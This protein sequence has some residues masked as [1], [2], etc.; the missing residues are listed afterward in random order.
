MRTSLLWLA[1]L[2]VAATAL[3]QPVP[4]PDQPKRATPP[5]EK[6]LVIRG[7]LKASDPLDR[8]RKQSYCRVHEVDL[9]AGRTYLVELRSPDFDT[10]L[11]VEDTQGRVLAENDDIGKTD[12]NSRL[13]IVPERRGTY[14]LVVTSFEGGQVGEYT[15][16]VQALQPEGVTQIVKGRLTGKSAVTAGRRVNL[17]KVRVQPERWYVIDLIS[18]EFDPYPVLRDRTGQLLGEDDDGG[19]NLNSRLLWPSGEGGEWQLQATSY[20]AGAT[21]SYTLRLQAHGPTIPAELTER[22]RWSF[23]ARKLTAEVARLR[24]T[25]N[26]AAALPKL[27]Q[28]RRLEEKLYPAEKF[29]QGHPDL[30]RSLNNLGY[31]LQARGDYGAAEDFYRRALAMSAKLYPKE[32][33]P[34]GHPDLAIS[35][36]N[37]GYFLQARGDY[38]AAEDFYRRALAMSAKLYPK[39]RYPQGHP[40]LARSLNNL[41]GLLQARGDYGGAEDFYRRALA[42]TTKLYSKERYPRGHPDL[43]TSLD[44]LGSLL[45]DRGD[46]GQAEDFYRRALAMREN[47]Y[48]KER[49]PQGH[50]DLAISLNNLGRFLEDRGDYGKAEPLLRRALAIMEMFYPQERYPQGHPY[51]AN[52]LNNLGYFLRVR[53][54]YGGAEPLLRRALTITEKL[55]PKE[56]YPQGHPD[57]ASSLNNLGYLLRARGGCG[58]AEPLLRRAVAMQQR[59]LDTFAGTAAESEGLLRLASLPSIRDDYLSLAGPGAP[60]AEA[61]YAAVW[62][63]KSALARLLRARRQAL[64]ATKDPATRDLAR[65]LLATRQELARLLF[66]PADTVTDHGDRVRKLSDRKEELEKQLAAKLS[67]FKAFLASGRR[68]PAELIERLPEGVAF[69]DLLRYVRFEQDAKTPGKKGERRLERYVAFVLAH[70]RPIQRTELKEAD[71]IDKAVDAW[72]QDIATGRGSSKAAATLQEKVWAL[73]AA[74]LPAGTRVV[75]LAPDGAL[76]RL[77]WAALP[78][79]RPGSYL[80][81]EYGLATV[82]YGQFLLETLRGNTP[83]PQVNGLLLAVGDVAFGQPPAPGTAAGGEM[84]ASRA[85]VL[86]EEKQLWPALPG[87]AGELEQ[88]QKLAAPRPVLLLKGAQAG[89]AQ[90]LA[91]LPKARWAHLATHG[92]FAD[93]RFRSVLHL[94]AEDYERGR[95]GERVGVGAKNPLVLSGLVL[96][97]ANLPKTPDRG[98]LTAEALAGLDLGGLD[99]AVL[100]ACETG[101]GDVAGGEGVF[102]LA[103]GFHAAGAH[104]VVASLWKV[105]DAATQRLMTLFYDNLWHKKLPRL[106]ALRQAQL[107]LLYDK[108]GSGTSRGPG[109]VMPSHATGP[110]RALPLVW[111]AWMLSGD[112]GD[113]SRIRPSVPPV[114]VAANSPPEGTAAERSTW[115]YQ[116]GAV[117]AVGLGLALAGWTWR[118]QRRWRGSNVS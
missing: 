60:T 72:R 88:V 6:S 85:P 41:G 95:R 46:Y 67:A 50:R 73:L 87:T 74:A 19:G 62:D 86:V 23:E 106:E 98:I 105:D 91:G 78:G 49:Y 51:L 82:P 58:G 114:T 45:E 65:Q 35:L 1:P 15:V 117:L 84:V 8:L 118:R 79:S 28:A 16:Q 42:T 61:A 101:L 80:L 34:Q 37:L 10:F 5:P 18:T 53:G 4:L 92:F 33:Y 104:T 107:A 96:A 59:L 22:E 32:R 71:D 66:A 3:A 116:L 102:G 100:S 25:G 76:T 115:A 99:L 48:P 103:R 108:A 39:E 64:L 44:N 40:D 75:I 90:V 43:A 54:D 81:E 26:N 69:V 27:E 52:S 110:P 111:A 2:L 11:R 109:E 63:T 93:A 89:T 94:S 7:E 30:A 21:G 55:Y 68:R 83:A 38:S 112:P 9:K 36:N 31:F 17:H 57:L 97:G 13:A 29:P 77:P 113:T 14:R 12:L 24:G 70:G 56:R 20:K 47:L